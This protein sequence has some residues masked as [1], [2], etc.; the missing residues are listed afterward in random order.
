MLRKQISTCLNMQIS[1]SRYVQ[2]GVFVILR[3]HWLLMLLK[4]MNKF[5]D[6]NGTYVMSGNWG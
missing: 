4:A 5:A 6:L 1:M 2:Y 3:P